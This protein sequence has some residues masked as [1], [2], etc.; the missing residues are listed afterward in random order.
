MTSVQWKSIAVLACG[1]I[2][3]WSACKKPTLEGTGVLPDSQLGL[4]VVDTLKILTY[5]ETDDTVRT[6]EQSVNILGT[7]HD[8]ELGTSKAGMYMNFTLDRSNIDL[9]SSLTADSM[10]LTLLYS[11]STK[12]YGDVTI[13]QNISVQRVTERMYADSSYF[14]NTTF[15]TDVSTLAQV[16][17]FVPN[18]TDSLVIDGVTYPPGLRITLDNSLAQEFLNQSGGTNLSTDA[19]FK[20]WFNGLYISTDATGGG[21]VYFDLFNSVSK[22]TLYYNDTS[23]IDFLINS[24]SATVNRYEHDPSTGNV[25]AV[26]NDTTKN[27][28]LYVK[29]M[30][31]TRGIIKVPGLKDLGSNISINQAELV[32]TVV[33]A[34]TATYKLPT[35]MIMTVVDADGEEQFVP[36]LLRFSNL[37]FF[38]GDLLITSDDDGNVVSQYTFNLPIYFQQIVNGEEDRGLRLLTFPTSR[39]AN[40][41]VLGGSD[42]GQSAVKLHL[43]YTKTQ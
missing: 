15:T 31:G 9:G 4:T 18:L 40:R 36:E 38:N 19:A 42:H 13:P 25:G 7:M 2:L 5:T 34:D 22:M 33:N 3:F 17:G 30:A 27:T 8:P 14:N 39:Q 23:N 29:A 6:D 24:S 32:V 12:S 26:L 16:N 20:D 37:D 35:Q 43:V 28:E 10:V 21:Q 41:V 1:V 11:S